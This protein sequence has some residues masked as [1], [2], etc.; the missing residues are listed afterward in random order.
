[1][2]VIKVT[3]KIFCNH[4]DCL[5]K[6]IRILDTIE[7]LNVNIFQKDDRCLTVPTMI[8][9]N[10]YRVFEMIKTSRCWKE[11][12]FEVQK[13][14]IYITRIQEWRNHWCLGDPKWARRQRREKRLK[15]NCTFFEIFTARWSI[16]PR[17]IRPLVSGRERRLFRTNNISTFPLKRIKGCLFITI[18]WEMKLDE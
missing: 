15:Y 5:N 18:K 1:M 11:V 9:I 7:D 8:K 13:W 16:I 12:D 3:W 4:H 10:S 17:R 14:K 6:L 2:E